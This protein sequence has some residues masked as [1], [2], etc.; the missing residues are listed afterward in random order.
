VIS[1]GRVTS[2]AALIASSQ[3]PALFAG[4]T[5]SQL[6]RSFHDL[7]E[8]IVTYDEAFELFCF[9]LFE[10]ADIEEFL[11]ASRITVEDGARGP[12]TIRSLGRA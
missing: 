8:Q 5:V 1:F 10:G 4:L 6:P 12:L 9:G 2:V 3:D 7:I 11:R